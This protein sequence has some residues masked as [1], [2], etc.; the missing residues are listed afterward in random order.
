MGMNGQ[1]VDVKRHVDLA[2]R[3]VSSVPSMDFR[4]DKEITQEFIA[5]ELFLPANMYSIPRDAKA[6]L[7]ITAPPIA[8]ER[9]VF[10]DDTNVVDPASLRPERGFNNNFYN[11]VVY[12]YEHAAIDDRFL[13]GFVEY[14]ADSYNRFESL[15]EKI[16][17]QSF[18]IE[19]K[20]LR[21]TA[22]TNVIVS[23]NAKNTLGRFEFAPE[24]IPDVRVL[25]K[26]G[27]KIEVGDIVA[28]GATGLKILNISNGTRVGEIKL[29]EVVN[30][31]LDV[32]TCE[33]VLSLLQTSFDANGRYGLVAPSTKISTGSTTTKIYFK[34]GYYMTSFL[35]ERKKWTDF[36]GERI[37]ITNSDYSYDHTT[38]LLS[39]SDTEP[40]VMN[41]TALPSPPL[42]NYVIDLADYD[43][44]SASLQLRQKLIYCHF[45]PQLTVASGISATQFTVSAPD[46]AKMSVGQM[47]QI[48]SSTYAVDSIDV[49][50][51]DITGTTITTSAIGFTPAAGQLIELVGFL[52]GGKPY[53]IYVG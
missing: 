12:K 24:L 50:V 30:K 14:S 41:V 1:E 42:A 40:D 18:I 17:N 48:H 8:D 25:S 46:A 29:Y 28:F 51:T 49:T 47:V 27:F 26:Y 38:T 53:R 16:G 9:S 19:S 32:K 6:S 23:L 37:R 45:N 22:E 10:L 2:L 21:D 34:L 3:F 13:K 39:L 15:G 5:K 4:L 7:G 43:T 33:V 52:D 35:N 11:S 44:S 31:S 36:I 20:G